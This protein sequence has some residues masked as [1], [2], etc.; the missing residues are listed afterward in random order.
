MSAPFYVLTASCQLSWPRH[1]FVIFLERRKGLRRGKSPPY[2]TMYSEVFYKNTLVASQLEKIALALDMLESAETAVR[3]ARHLLS[4]LT[5]AKG[6][7]K[8]QSL[9]QALSDANA[10]EM[11]GDLK[12]IEGVFDG[13][14]MIGK[15]N[16][17]YAV[18]ANYASKSK[19][20]SGD[21]LKLTIHPDGSYKYKQIQKVES[22][23]IMG[24]LTYDGGKYKVLANGKLY[25]VLL[26]SVTYF[27]GEVGDKVS[28]IV[29]EHQETDWA[30]VD[31][32]IPQ[33]DT[34]YGDEGIL[35][36]ALQNTQE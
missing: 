9:T 24:T 6:I 23:N 12:I 11:Q 22:K 30:T 21:L 8:K 26:A 36:E 1:S 20:V 10:P 33:S 18:P 13:E 5:G 14:R 31:V 27:K 4:E 16:H 28:I 29:P 7:V 34:E 17:Q 15:D 35:Q 25:N 3:S 2:G 19:L 32:I